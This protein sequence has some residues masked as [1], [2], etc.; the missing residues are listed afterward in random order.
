MARLRYAGVVGTVGS[1]GLTTTATSHTFTAPLTYASGVTLPTLAGTDYFMLSI[2]DTSGNLSEV[3]KVTAYNSGTGAATIARGQESTTGVTHSSGDK[4][5]SAVYTTDLPPVEVW[6]TYTPTW[7]ATSGTPAVGTGGSLTG[8]YFQVGKLVVFR[9]NLVLGTTGMSTGTGTWAFG[10]PV[11][12]I[13]APSGIGQHGLNLGGYFEDSGVRAY[14]QPGGRL[15]TS[16]TT[17]FEI[18]Y[19]LDS[20]TN[21]GSGSTVGATAPFTW[22][23]ADYL[24]VYGSYQA[25]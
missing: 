17:A 11:A 25:A 20:A 23:S 1:S 18:T 10:L 5:T 22:G 12:H 2:L 3:V 7:T 15:K 13:A 16:S 8:D 14:A 21:P 4:V 6:T 9:M 24:S 19:S